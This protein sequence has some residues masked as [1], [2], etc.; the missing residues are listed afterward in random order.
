MHINLQDF[1]RKTGNSLKF[2]VRWCIILE[3]DLQFAIW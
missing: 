2:H 1:V 3:T